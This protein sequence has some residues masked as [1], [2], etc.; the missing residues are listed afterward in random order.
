M[1]RFF[2]LDK[3]IFEVK[4]QLKII[5][6]IYFLKYISGDI[7]SSSNDVLLSKEVLT[8]DEH[9]LLE[10]E[11]GS[12]IPASSHRP[13]RVLIQG[14]NVSQVAVWNNKVFLYSENDE[15]LVN[16]RPHK[17]FMGLHKSEE[18]L[19]LVRDYVRQGWKVVEPPC[20]DYD[21]SE[22]YYVLNNKAVNKKVDFF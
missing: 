4:T 8:I 3:N 17:D 20:Y 5:E 14:E 22:S 7:G 16:K 2:R 1:L 15:S 19:N 21:N 12:F 18:Y 6:A 13:S 11:H 10:A 9:E